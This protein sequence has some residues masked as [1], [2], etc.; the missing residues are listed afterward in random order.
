MISSAF[1]TKML[2]EWV[3][4][5]HAACQSLITIL[6]LFVLQYLVKCKKF[7]IYHHTT[8]QKDIKNERAR[9][10]LI[11]S[12]HVKFV[13]EVRNS[14]RAGLLARQCKPTE[15]PIS[16]TMNG[17]IQV[18]RAYWRTQAATQPATSVPARRFADHATRST[19]PWNTS[20]HCTYYLFSN[21]K[22]WHF[23]RRTMFRVILAINIYHFPSC[24]GHG[25][26]S[27]KYELKFTSY[28]ALTICVQRVKVL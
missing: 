7:S 10:V 19:H 8:L 5:S 6:E 26:F 22:P 12:R 14:L 1:A 28:N 3:S 4:P 16:V 21:W 17:R 24:N 27:V 23:S 2:Y 9:E 13:P 25:L 20:R 11:I 15:A 18:T